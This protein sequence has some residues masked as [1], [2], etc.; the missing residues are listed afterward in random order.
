MDI[1]PTQQV[2]KSGKS[3]SSI[4]NSCKIFV[5][6]QPIRADETSKVIEVVDVLNYFI[7]YR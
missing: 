1:L 6:L 2:M 5:R 4:L 3:Q 7:L